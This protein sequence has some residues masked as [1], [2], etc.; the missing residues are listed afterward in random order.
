[1]SDLGDLDSMSTAERRGV[2]LPD[3]VLDGDELSDDATAR[4]GTEVDDPYGGGTEEHIS[5]DAMAKVDD[6]ASTHDENTA[7]DGEYAE[8]LE[9]KAN[10]AEGDDGEVRAKQGR[11]REEEPVVE[12]LKLG[13]LEGLPE[14]GPCRT[15]GGV[16]NDGGHEGDA[17]AN[18]VE[19]AEEA[20]ER[21]ALGL[22]RVWVHGGVIASE[23]RKIVRGDAY[24]YQT[25]R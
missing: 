23:K 24:P 7:V 6:G 14:G 15:D 19:R 9:V 21:T 11:E 13:E 3:L 8:V 17:E 2:L 10:P 1:V 25:S 20:G 16:D 5:F 4:R 12:E 22:C 18:A